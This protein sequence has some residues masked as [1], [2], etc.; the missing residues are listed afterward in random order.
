MSDEIIGIS[1]LQPTWIEGIYRL[2]FDARKSGG[3]IAQGNIFMRDRRRAD[4]PDKMPGWSE[5]TNTIWTFIDRPIRQIGEGWLD[6][7]P[8]VNWI[9]WGFHNGF[10]WSTYFVE[11]KIRCTEEGYNEPDKRHWNGHSVH[12]DLNRV[13]KTEAER[14]ALILELRA[15]GILR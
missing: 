9:S 11:M 10:N 15:Q 8:S 14:G 4:L 6:C 2:W 12:Y 7:Q 1:V 5:G 13:C 3:E